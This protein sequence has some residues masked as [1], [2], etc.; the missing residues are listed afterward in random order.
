MGVVAD[1]TLSAGGHAI[2]V[3]PDALV[4]CEIG[5][6]GLPDLP[7]LGSVH[8]RKALMASLS[9]GFMALLGG[10]DR[11]EEFCEAVT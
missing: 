10:F 3:I 11:F 9:D 7:V 8:E 5:H 6:A 4:A 2:G 1:A